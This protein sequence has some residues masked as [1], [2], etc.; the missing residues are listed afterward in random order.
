MTYEKLYR[1]YTEQ[2][3][4]TG[5]SMDEIGK[6][7]N[8]IGALY[9]GSK[10]K[11]PNLNLYDFLYDKVLQIRGLSDKTGN[12]KW[13]RPERGSMDAVILPVC[14]HVDL[15]LTQGFKPT[16]FGMK[17]VKEVV[18]TINEILENRVPF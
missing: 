13:E 4:I 5:L 11:N 8:L 15:Y 6:L 17:D 10:K 2:F 7:L 9:L 16:T 1:I 12:F 3:A 14:L 18:R